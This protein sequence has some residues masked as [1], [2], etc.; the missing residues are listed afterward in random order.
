M[1]NIFF[2]LGY[3]LTMLL[4]ILHNPAFSQTITT[5]AGTGITGSGGD[6]GQA[7]NAQLNYPSCIAFDWQG[8]MYTSDAGTGGSRVRKIRP[9]GIITTY[10]GTGISG[11]SGDGGPATAAQLKQPT[12]LVVDGHGNLYIA[13]YADNRIRRVDTGGIIS[14]FA[15]TGSTGLYS[16]DGGP[17]TL[18]ELRN[19]SDLATD[20]AGNVYFSQPGSISVIRKINTA[21][22]ISTIAGNGTA[23]FSGD[24]G[25]ATLAQFNI[26]SGVAVDGAGNIY[27][28]DNYNNRVRKIEYTGIITT[29]GG[30]GTGPGGYSGDGG[31]ATLALL[32]RPTGITIDGDGTIYFS[33]MGNTCI[34]KIDPS[35]MI[36]TYAGTNI[37][38]FSGDGGPATAANLYHPYGV[39][40]SCNA[41]LFICDRT[42]V[43]IRMVS[44]GNTAPVFTVG[45]SQSISICKDSTV[46]V[47]AHLAVIDADTGQRITWSAKRLP[48]NGTLAAA[49]STMSTGGS[50]VPTS[51]TYAPSS[52][53]TGFDT[54]TVLVNDCNYTSDTVTFYMTINPCPLYINSVAYSA[55]SLKVSPNPSNGVITLLLSSVL[56]EQV[57]FTVSNPTGEVITKIN[58]YTNTP[59]SLKAEIAPGIYFVQ[60]RTAHGSESAKLVVNK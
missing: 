43:R 48:A 32:K 37:T 18:A 28:C 22:I 51:F 16:G 11:Y 2:I 31:P 21:G 12:G 30:S 24:G 39:A 53:Y 45:R 50:I 15:G 7:T 40:L 59:A 1:K 4:S 56:T 10:A 23:G 20:E 52:G 46:D 57:L 8:N 6:G 17:A 60:A 19:P 14:T 36:S 3:T 42:N 55:Q 44:N 41:N 25:P 33:D 47:S 38:G 58:S 9:T 34:R 27:V 13:D 5:V 54:F 35:G 26:P 49:F 29:I